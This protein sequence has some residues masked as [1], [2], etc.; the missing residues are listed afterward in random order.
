M[1]VLRRTL[2]SLPFLLGSAFASEDV[3]VFSDAHIHSSYSPLLQEKNAKADSLLPAL[4]GDQTFNEL[5]RTHPKLWSIER[6][7]KLGELVTQLDVQVIY[8]DGV[9]EEQFCDLDKGQSTAEKWVLRIG[10]DFTSGGSNTVPIHVQQCLE[11]V[12]GELGY[13]VRKG[14][15]VVEIPARK[16]LDEIRRSKIPDALDPAL[17][18]QVL[19]AHNEVKVKGECPTNIEAYAIL[20]DVWDEVKTTSIN[21]AALNDH[22]NPDE[23]GGRVVHSCAFSREWNQ[24]YSEESSLYCDEATLRCK[25]VQ[26]EDGTTRWLLDPATDAFVFQPLWGL[27]GGRSV[28]KGGSM[29]DLRILTLSSSMFLEAYLDEKGAP[30]TLGLITVP[31]EKTP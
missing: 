20:L 4:N 8:I 12:R 11:S 15:R 18:A 3:S 13:K 22:L 16:V 9:R 31:E 30:I 24:K 7:D 28:H 26:T 29:L 19:K 10:V 23:I 21:V 6:L 5:V 17:Q 2:L 27:F 14:D 1:P 25:Y